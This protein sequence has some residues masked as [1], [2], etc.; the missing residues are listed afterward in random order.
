MILEDMFGREGIDPPKT[1][2]HQHGVSVH[3]TVSDFQVYSPVGT[4]VLFHCMHM[5][6][7]LV[8]RNL[9]NK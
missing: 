8:I 6:L 5:F 4:V 9:N 3:C 7:N 1:K 2:L